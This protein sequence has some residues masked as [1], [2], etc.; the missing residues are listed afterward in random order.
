M[1]SI[2]TPTNNTKYIYELW[3]SIKN[4]TYTDWEWIILTNGDAEVNIDDPRVRIIKHPRA[5]NSVDE[6]KLAAFMEARG[7]IV[8]EVD[9]DDLITPT[10]LEEVAKAFEDPEIGF[11]YSNNAK[12][13]DTFTPYNPAFGWT[14]REF[15]WKDK[16]YWE[17]TSFEPSAGSFSFIWFM[18]DHIRAWRKSVYVSIGGHNPS[19]EVLDDQDLMLRTYLATKVKYIDKCLYLY[20]ITGDNT[21]LKRNELIQ[22]NTVQ[23]YHQY[24][25]QIAERWSDLNNLL[26]VDLGG[27]FNKPEGYISIDLKN[28]DITADLTK[29]IPLPDNS[30]GV[31]RAHDFLEHLPDKQFII[32]EIYRVLADGGVFLSQTPSTEGKGAFMDPTHVS[33]WNEGSFW[34]YTRRDQAQFIYNDKIKFQAFRLE[35]AFPSD[36]A[37]NNNI[38]YVVAHLYAIKSDKRRPNLQTI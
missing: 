14:K 30:V 17:M 13:S 36:W 35:T 19:L 33:Y 15:E 3:D 27:G 5:T 18:P 6:L 31:I 24:A 2:T 9:H 38:P 16:K 7:D 29:G 32:S 1:I 37:K 21:W 34:Y 26:K 28:G 23:I 25:Y 20:R 22:T 10:C 11:A 8:A 12:Y 4:Q